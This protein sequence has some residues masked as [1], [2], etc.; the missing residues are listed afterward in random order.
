[1]QDVRE[2]AAGQGRLGSRRRL[3]ASVVHVH[4][5][6]AS[7]ISGGSRRVCCQLQGHGSGGFSRHRCFPGNGSVERPQ[8]PGLHG[9]A[10]QRGELRGLLGRLPPSWLPLRAGEQEG[11]G[12]GPRPVRSGW[13]SAVPHAVALSW[14]R[15]HTHTQAWCHLRSGA[16]P[17][18][19]SGSSRS[20]QTQCILVDQAEAPGG[21]GGVSSS[22]HTSQGPGEKA[23]GTWGCRG[24][25]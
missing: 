2:L 8:V 14:A 25:G 5:A 15:T 3:L 7:S 20:V 19:S 6:V 4:P 9:A 22:S 1:M 10:G 12:W 16:G 18:A 11:G 13:D 17:G 21:R 23:V 24:I